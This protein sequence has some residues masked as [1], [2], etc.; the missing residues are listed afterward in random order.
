MNRVSSIY[1]IGE[2]GGEIIIFW[3]L[4]II[5]LFVVSKVF[6]SYSNKCTKKY[7]DGQKETGRIKNRS[8]DSGQ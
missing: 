7:F 5:K 4:I 1:V 3:C 8:D 6:Y 2:G